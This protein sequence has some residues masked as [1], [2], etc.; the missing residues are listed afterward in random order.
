[1]RFLLF[2]WAAVVMGG[3]LTLVL[4]AT[5]TSLRE[6]MEEKAAGEVFVLCCALSLGVL[7]MVAW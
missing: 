3:L 6:Y 7:M 5:S 4:A 1:M 2:L